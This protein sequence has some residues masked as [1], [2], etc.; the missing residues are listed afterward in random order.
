MLPETQGGF[1]QLNTILEYPLT[2][3]NNGDLGADTFDFS[4]A[5]GWNLALYTSD[6]ITLLGD[7]DGDGMV[8]TGAIAPGDSISLLARITPPADPTAGNYNFA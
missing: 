1:V 4:V 3:K 6:G 7:T 8:D 2:I 5:S